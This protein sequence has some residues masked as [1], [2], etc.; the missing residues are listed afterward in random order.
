MVYLR[1]H[2]DEETANRFCEQTQQT[3]EF[4][5][6]QPGV[7]RQRSELKPRGLQTWRVNGFEKWLIF[8]RHGGS[9]VEIFRVKHAMMDLPKLFG[10]E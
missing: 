9:E 6:K 4:L 10:K 7:G 5:A 3:F 8:Y 1:D 2:A